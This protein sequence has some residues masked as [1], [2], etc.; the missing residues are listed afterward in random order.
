M[1]RSWKIFLDLQC[2]FSKKMWQNLPSIK[3]RFVDEFEFEIYITSLAFHPQA[4]T[5][6]CG[7]SLIESVKG[8]D[9]MFKYVD[10][11]YENQDAF[12]NA[13][14]GDARKSDIDSVFAC[15][16]EKAGLFDEQFTKEAFLEDLHSWEKAVKP[17]YTEHKIALNYNAYGAPKNVIDEKLVVESESAWDADDWAEKLKTL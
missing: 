6:Q 7:A 2:P 12:M 15:I 9:V 14:I 11:C 13:S 16:A 10:A 1:K 3:E 5:A 8:R 17:A 4:F